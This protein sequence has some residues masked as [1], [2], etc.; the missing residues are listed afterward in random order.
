MTSLNIRDLAPGVIRGAA[1]V[2]ATYAALFL[3]MPTLTGV[4]PVSLL[5][6]ALASSSA[7]LMNLTGVAVAQSQAVLTLH[8]AS[9]VV[10]NECNGLGA[11]L[12]I[13]GAMSAL[14]G[15]A[16]R[17]RIAGM[18]ASALVVSAVNVTRIAALCYLQAEQ[19]AWFSPFHE[20]IAPL[21]VVLTA[22]LCF[23]CWIRGLDYAHQR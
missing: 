2:A 8:G 1:V 4:N 20:Q 23:A 6:L 14:P 12:L 17:W 15:V 10:T 11:W 21:L 3:L 9:V 18:A 13:V 22:A 16:W 7:F 5:N 19:P